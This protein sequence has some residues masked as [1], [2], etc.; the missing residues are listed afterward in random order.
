MNSLNENHTIGQKALLRGIEKLKISEQE[1][2]EIVKLAE[3]VFNTI[4]KK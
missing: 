1:K 4:N 2:A 3:I